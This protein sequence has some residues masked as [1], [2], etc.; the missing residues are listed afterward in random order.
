[1]KIFIKNMVCSR[2]ILVVKSVFANMNIKPISVSLGEVELA[3]NLEQ[4]EAEQLNQQLK[5]LG[6]EIIDDKKSKMI[7]KIKN[8]IITIIHHQTEYRLIYLVTFQSN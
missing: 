3:A 8:I 5:N 4:N 1:M 2:C 7:E 6:F